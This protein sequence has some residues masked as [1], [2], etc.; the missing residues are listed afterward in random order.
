M[1]KVYEDHILGKSCC[2]MIKV[3]NTRRAHRGMF[4]KK[5]IDGRIVYESVQKENGNSAAKIEFGVQNKS[6]KWYV[7]VLYGQSYSPYSDHQ[8]MLAWMKNSEKEKCPPLKK[9]DG[10]GG[11][12]I[13]CFHGFLKPSF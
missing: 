8:N 11:G 2:K 7:T 13:V 3:L 1:K 9:F 12:E 6:F 4:V 10:Q 5:K